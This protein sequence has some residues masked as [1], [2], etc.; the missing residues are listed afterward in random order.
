MSQAEYL[1]QSDLIKRGWSRA[2]VEKFLTHPCHEKHLGWGRYAYLYSRRRVE[3]AEMFPDCAK[4]IAAIKRGRQPRKPLGGIPLTVPA[5][6][7]HGN[8]LIMTAR[9]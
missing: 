9:A 2:L 7:R 8:L 3:A 4:R 6:T 1:L 5:Y